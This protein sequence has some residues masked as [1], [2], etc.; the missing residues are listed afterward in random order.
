M[1]L[2][3]GTLGAV[4][5]ASVEPMFEPLDRKQISRR[6]S[7]AGLS[8]AERGR[9]GSRLE[10]RKAAPSP[11]AER[12]ASRPLAQSL[13]SGVRLQAGWGGTR[14]RQ[15]GREEADSRTGSGSSCPRQTFPRTKGDCVNPLPSRHDTTAA[16]RLQYVTGELS[17]SRESQ[18][19]LRA[20]RIGLHIRR[21]PRCD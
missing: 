20:R 3:A 14:A 9:G 21:E 18:P 19:T 12:T 11:T 1:S 15:R 5:Q 10:A 6:S 13:L 4:S 17:R 16:C 8:S 7:T 2:S